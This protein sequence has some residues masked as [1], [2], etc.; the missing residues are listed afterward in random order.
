MPE[1]YFLNDPNGNGFETF[2]TKEECEKNADDAI[3]YYLHDG[4]DEEVVNVVTGIITH[5]ATQ[6]DREERPNE[7]D[8]EE[9][10]GEGQYWGD[11]E[12]RCNYKLK[13]V[14]A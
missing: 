11:F 7:L 8:E 13:P 4:W 6:T 14:K 9:C 3:Q 12:Y 2:T 1:L 5:Q 10:D